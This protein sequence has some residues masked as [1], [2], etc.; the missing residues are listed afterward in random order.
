[1]RN[2]PVFLGIRDALPDGLHHI[3]VIQHFVHRAVV[4]QPVEKGPNSLFGGLKRR[5]PARTID[6]IRPVQIV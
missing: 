4:W 6:S 2:D 3:Q 5:I 1:M